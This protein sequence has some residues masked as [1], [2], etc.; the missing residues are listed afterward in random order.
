MVGGGRQDFHWLNSPL[1]ILLWS[2]QLS[3]GQ[4]T[5]TP[6][7]PARQTKYLPQQPRYARRKPT[8]SEHGTRFTGALS[9]GAAQEH[10]Q[11][12]LSQ[13]PLTWCRSSIFYCVVAR[14]W[15]KLMTTEI[16]PFTLRVFTSTKG[17][18]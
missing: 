18:P 8:V 4:L 16:L 10:T 1:T 17:P 12:S 15:T 7:M 13:R 5:S 9:I 2:T 11:T 3:I 6:P 14:R